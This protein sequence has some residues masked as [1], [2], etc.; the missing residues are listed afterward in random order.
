M[1]DSTTAT[2]TGTYLKVSTSE[3]TGG[4]YLGVSERTGSSI[5]MYDPATLDSIYL[6]QSGNSVSNYP[7]S[8]A[9]SD[10]DKIGRAHV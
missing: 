2:N 10:S 6:D 4:L 8:L 3:Y 5:K 9:V 7:R 1:G